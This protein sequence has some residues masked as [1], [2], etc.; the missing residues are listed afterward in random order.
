MMLLDLHADYCD[1]IS[2]WMAAKARGEI[3]EAAKLLELARVE[4]GK[5]EIELMRYFDHTLVFSELGYCQTTKSKVN[6][7]VINL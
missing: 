4:F 1:L 5:H 7:N 3:E 6:N 2:D